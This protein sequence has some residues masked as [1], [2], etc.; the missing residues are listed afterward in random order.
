MDVLSYERIASITDLEVIENLA[1]NMVKVDTDDNGTIYKATSPKISVKGNWF[2]LFTTD[3]IEKILGQTAVAQAGSPVTGATQTWDLNTVTKDKFYP[4]TNQNAS[5]LVPTITYVKQGV[6]TLTLHTDYEVIQ[7]ETGVRG[8]VFLTAFDATKTTILTYDYTPAAAK[9]QGSIIGPKELPAL[10]VKITS[11]D[12]ET[13]KNRIT[14]LCN[15]GLESDLVS[16]FIDVIRAKDMK[17]TPFE[18]VGNKL[19]FILK[20]FEV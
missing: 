2:E 13:N 3:V 9:Y 20:Y 6:T 5:G 10:V 1:E 15:C 4:I 12:T 11:L 17:P 14:Y 19:G 16:S 18:F 8:L 7:D